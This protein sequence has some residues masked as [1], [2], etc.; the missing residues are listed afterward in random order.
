MNKKYRI[1]IEFLVLQGNSNNII[2]QQLFKVYGDEAPSQRTVDTWASKIRKGNYD[3]NDKKRVGRPVNDNLCISIKNLLD[4]EPFL[5]AKKISSYLMIPYTTV[6][7]ILKNRLEYRKFFFRWVPYKLTEEIKDI[8]V[9]KSKKMLTF[10]RNTN[11]YPWRTIITG[12]ESWIY[13]QN[14]PSS[15]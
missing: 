5:S 6:T 11:K 14:S 2:Y 8:R 4:K 7:H 12:D 13:F 1:I 15:I 10:L 3:L 9:K